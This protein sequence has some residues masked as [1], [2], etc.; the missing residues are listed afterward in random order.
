MYIVAKLFAIFLLN[1]FEQA[2]EERVRKLT[3]WLSNQG[4]GSWTKQ[5]FILVLLLEQCHR[6]SL[7]LIPI[8]IDFAAVFDSVER[9]VLWRIPRRGLNAFTFCGNVKSSHFFTLLGACYEGRGL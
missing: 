8:F 1:R 4:G 2:R 3:S 7:L 9:D 6:Y 5:I